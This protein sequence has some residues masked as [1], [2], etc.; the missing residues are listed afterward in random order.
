MA[1]RDNTDFTIWGSGT[2]LRQFIYNVDLAELMIWTLRSY[3]SI[4]PLILS[5]DESAEISIKDVALAV[6]KGM[7]FTGNVVMDSTKSDGQ[8]KKTACNDKLRALRP[9]YKFTT[10]EAGVAEACRWFEENFETCRKG[11]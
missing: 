7:G 1:K 8:F 10:F 5:V 11:H 6:A 4:E 2:P 3:D 9:D